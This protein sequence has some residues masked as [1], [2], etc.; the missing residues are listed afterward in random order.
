VGAPTEYITSLSVRPCSCRTPHAASSL[1]QTLDA[2]VWN[3]LWTGKEAM[4]KGMLILKMKAG[5]ESVKDLPRTAIGY[6]SKAFTDLPPPLRLPTTS[7]GWAKSPSACAQWA[8]PSSHPSHQKIYAGV[9]RSRW[10]ERP[11]VIINRKKVQSEC[12]ENSKTLQRCRQ[13]GL[14]WKKLS[15]SSKLREAWRRQTI[16]CPTT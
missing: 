12:Q 13:S 15:R 5:F 7:N 6:S 3:L 11:R 1:W 4:Q 9:P 10:L 8:R 14:N 2:H 16:R